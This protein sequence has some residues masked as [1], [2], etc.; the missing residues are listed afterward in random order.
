MD[1]VRR[2]QAKRLEIL[3]IYDKALAEI[4]TKLG[5]ATLKSK[6]M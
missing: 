1:R 3:E 6:E 2:F 4:N 5:A